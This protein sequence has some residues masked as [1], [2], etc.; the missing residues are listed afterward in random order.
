MVGLVAAF[1]IQWPHVRI[2]RAD[3]SVR[4]S[5]SQSFWM[6]NPKSA[7]GS[8]SQIQRVLDILRSPMDAILVRFVQHGA[9]FFSAVSS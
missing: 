1:V 8:K 5:K 7:A 4:V 9:S 2:I 6:G 3:S